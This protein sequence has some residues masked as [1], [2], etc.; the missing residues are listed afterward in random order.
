M[1]MR[2]HREH[3]PSTTVGGTEGVRAYSP[4]GLAA[5]WK[6]S[7]KHVRNLLNSGQLRGWKL[8]GKLWRIKPDAVE[9]YE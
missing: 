1:E 2:P 6:C 7:E 4:S 5:A 8:G 3:S 9:E